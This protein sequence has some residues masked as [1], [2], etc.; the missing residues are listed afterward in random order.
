M[1]AYL[2]IGSQKCLPL[3]F[4]AEL[5]TC[6][7]IKSRVAKLVH[8]SVKFTDHFRSKSASFAIYF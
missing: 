7:W 8:Q 2:T 3:L 5:K 6:H 4:A 1:L